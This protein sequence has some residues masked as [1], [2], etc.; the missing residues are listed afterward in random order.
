MERR[1]F[2]KLPAIAA[3]GS[4]T[5]TL[6]DGS[7]VMGDFGVLRLQPGDIV[8]VTVDRVIFHEQQEQIHAILRSLVPEHVKVAVVTHGV[9]LGVI[10]PESA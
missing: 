7:T 3:L 10:R 5:L 8:A 9:S 4:V 1:D 6:R 2:L